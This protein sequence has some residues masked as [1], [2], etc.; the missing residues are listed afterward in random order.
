MGPK[1]VRP[2]DEALAQMVSDGLTSQQI[3][4]ILSDNQEF[5]MSRH[6]VDIWRREA[7]CG[8]GRKMVSRKKYLPW[9]LV[10]SHGWD[11][12]AR[13][14]RSLDRRESGMTLNDT[15]Q[16]TV[17]DFLDALRQA[18][19]VVNYDPALGFYF[20]PRNPDLDEA[21]DWVRRPERVA[22]ARAAA[23]AE[24]RGRRRA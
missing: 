2:T 10:G 8:A 23:Q 15:E 11:D 21:T 12:V 6:T 14:L 16:R 7:G 19:K 24:T 20:V 13:V 1:D 3:A 4:N 9:T 17:E 22:A 5:T 18:N